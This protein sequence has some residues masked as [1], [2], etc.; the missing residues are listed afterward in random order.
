VGDA[1]RTALARY[2]ERERLAEL[3]PNDDWYPPSVF[4]QGM[5][6]VF[7]GDPTLRL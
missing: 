7:L 1:W 6:F 2:V 5:K 3:V 4:F